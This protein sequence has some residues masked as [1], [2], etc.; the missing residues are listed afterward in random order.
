MNLKAFVC[1]VQGR[2]SWPSPFWRAQTANSGHTYVHD[3]ETCGLSMTSFAMELAL[4]ECAERA[5]EV[6]SNGKTLCHE[7]LMALQA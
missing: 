5:D 7:V 1:M 4:R 6:D 2:Q 3:T